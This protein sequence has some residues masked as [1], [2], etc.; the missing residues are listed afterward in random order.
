MYGG[1]YVPSPLF[2]VRWAVCT[3]TSVVSQLVITAPRWCVIVELISPFEIT[4]NP[5][6][7]GLLKAALFV[8]C[9]ELSPLSYD[10]AAVGDKCVGRGSSYLP[11]WYLKEVIREQKIRESCNE[12]SRR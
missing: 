3:V 9:N 12:G 5:L 11:S 4:K 6:Q 1:L 2:D 7:P 10:L 8:L